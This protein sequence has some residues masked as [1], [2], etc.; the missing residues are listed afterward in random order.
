VE[1]D[2]WSREGCRV[3]VNRELVRRFIAPEDP[4]GKHVVSGGPQ[5]RSCEIVGVVADVLDDGLTM[6][7]RNVVYGAKTSGGG[8]VMLLVR[9]RS[10]PTR[11]VP[12]LRR[13]LREID[14]ELALYRI[15]TL[16][17]LVFSAA[18][19]QHWEAMILSGLG[20]L[21]LLLAAL[22]VYGVMA[23]SVARR[24][25]DVG[26]ELALGATPRRIMR[27]AMTRGLRLALV[28]IGIGL[29]GS[30]VLARLT[31]SQ[32]YGVEA[33]DLRT[34]AASSA[35]LLLVALTA[36]YFPA[37]R[38]TQVDPTEALRYE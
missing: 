25:H 10:D 14:P 3:I 34:L 2:Q 36:S 9:T 32:L 38:A 27:E 24:T 18:W 20:G 31:A 37:R 35:T 15:T 17:K 28:G 26:I 29:F 1:T 6:P 7:P 11:F 12:Q 13:E 33:A 21:G 8:I 16:E 22:G 23:Y 30:L 5:G 4:L 19:Y